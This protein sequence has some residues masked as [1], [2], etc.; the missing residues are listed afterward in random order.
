[1]ELC[2]AAWREEVDLR[3]WLG[4]CIEFRLG[5]LLLLLFPTV[6]FLLSLGRIGRT[7]TQTCIFVL[8]SEGGGTSAA[9]TDDDD[10]TGPVLKPLAGDIPLA[11]LLENRLLF[12]LL[13]VLTPPVL[14]TLA[15][16]LLTVEPPP[17]LR[18]DITSFWGEK[19]PVSS[20][21]EES[22]VVSIGCFLFLDVR[23]EDVVREFLLGGV[24]S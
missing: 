15:L 14:Q 9:A 17:M 2:N 22:V 13:V 8:R 11:N 7:R 19:R 24:L 6:A 18:R 20:I 3:W 21:E 12:R 16:L 1:M 5:L 4:A 10:D 23:V